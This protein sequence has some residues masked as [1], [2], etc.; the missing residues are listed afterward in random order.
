MRVYHRQMFPGEITWDLDGPDPWPEMFGNPIEL[1]EQFLNEPPSLIAIDT[2][3]ISVSN[4]TLLGVG[5]A[6]SPRESFYITENDPDF[7]GLMLVLEA[8]AIKKVYHNAPFDMRVL[9]EWGVD[10]YNVEDT[11]IMCRLLNIPAVLEQALDDTRYFGYDEKGYHIQCGSPLRAEDM[12]Y[13][14]GVKRMDQMPPERLAWKCCTDSEAT[15]VLYHHLSRFINTN[16]PGNYKLERDMIPILEET[17]QK[18]VRLDQDRRAEL[19]EYYQREYSFY[20]M[21]ADGMGFKIGSNYEVGFMIAEAGHFMNLRGGKKQFTV[22]EKTLRKIHTPPMAMGI[23]QMTL[24]YRHV[25]GMLSRYIRPLEGQDRAY[26]MMHMDAVT[27]R[28]SPGG[29]GKNNPDRNL[30][31]IPKK[32]EKGV[33][34]PIRSM[35]VGDDYPDPESG[36]THADQKQVE[37]V[38]LAYLSKDPIMQGVFERNEDIHDATERAIWGTSGPNRPIAKIFNFAMIYSYGKVEVVAENVGVPDL[39]K[40]AHWINLWMTTYAGAAQWMKQQTI[41]GVQAGYV[42]TL[43]G[44]RL[45]IPMEQGQEHAENCCINYPIQGTAAECFKL[46]IQAT[47]PLLDQHRIYIHDEILFNGDVRSQLDT[48]ELQHVSEIRTPVEVEI[49]RRWSGD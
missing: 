25:Q 19:E 10:H 16:Y 30:A 36:L 1:W 20:S 44:R 18:G 27:G 12:L 3:T 23:A 47:M 14:Y 26:T 39:A 22:D 42:E 40:V 15:L 38:I 24:Q 9:R 31:N 48:E 7:P 17:S 2:E 5:V 6:I 49:G 4:R 46:L 43:H 45:L 28:V 33:A 8:H 34:P 32:V 13:E 35:F 37:L 11:A 21:T 41:D 29:A